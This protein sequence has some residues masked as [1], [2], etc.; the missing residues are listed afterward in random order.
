MKDPR[1]LSDYAQSRIDALRRE[2]VK[3]SDENV[4]VINA[5]AW[6]VQSPCKRVSLARGKPVK[7]GN[8][9]L[10]PLTANASAWFSEV[11]GEMKCPM[12]TSLKMWMYR[13]LERMSFSEIA[14]AYA[15]AHRDDD[16]YQTT[17]E[18]ILAWF[19]TFRGTIDELRVAMGYVMLQVSRDEQPSSKDDALTFEE[20]VCYMH[21]THGGSAQ[22]WA[23]AVSIGYIYD[24]IDTSMKQSSADG[25]KEQRNRAEACLSL[26]CHKLRKAA[27][28]V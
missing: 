18:M 5:L 11:G 3:L 20:L 16:Q 1:K 19:K 4:C 6:E 9:W 7:C 14:L 27:K 22:A 26:Y 12:S 13:I 10:W 17:P 8:V 25:A 21:A 23:Q 28:N 24:Y 15:M 2:G